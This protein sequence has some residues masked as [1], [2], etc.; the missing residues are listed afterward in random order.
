MSAII[1]RFIE[2]ETGIAVF[3]ADAATSSFGKAG[4]AQKA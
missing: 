1:S 2:N 3:A 4:T